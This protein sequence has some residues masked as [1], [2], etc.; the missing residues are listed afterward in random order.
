MVRKFSA[1][2]RSMARV[3]APHYG[4][5]QGET[6]QNRKKYQVFSRRVKFILFN[7]ELVQ[8]YTTDF[9]S[10]N[11]AYLRSTHTLETGTNECF[12]HLCHELLKKK[13]NKKILKG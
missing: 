2:G 8:D 11:F 12:S 6:G 4:S 9:V 13:T 7:S 10:S 1:H 5:N 3:L